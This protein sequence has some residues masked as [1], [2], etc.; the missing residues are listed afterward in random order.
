MSKI[1]TFSNFVLFSFL[2]L[3]LFHFYPYNVSVNVKYVFNVILL[4]I[5]LL[6]LIKQC[7]LA[8]IQ[9]INCVFI[10]LLSFTTNQELF[11]FIKTYQI[12]KKVC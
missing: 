7:C 10:E 8:L 2:S 6:S 9:N 3:K 4:S 1:T 11:I 5:S 12:R